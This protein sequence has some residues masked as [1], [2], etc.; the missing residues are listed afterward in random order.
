MDLYLDTGL[1]R[2]TLRKPADTSQA[3]FFAMDNS[4]SFKYHDLTETF[5]RL[6]PAL[7]A[8]CNSRFCFLKLT[9]P[10]GEHNLQVANAHA[11]LH[12]SQFNFHHLF[13]LLT[14]TRSVKISYLSQYLQ[15]PTLTS[16]ILLKHYNH[17]ITFIIETRS[18]SQPHPTWQILR[19]TRLAT[20]TIS[21]LKNRDTGRIASPG[22]VT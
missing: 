5:N 6:A 11:S 12:Q 21:W 16:D 4:Q 14:L 8:Y 18:H 2:L 7:L 1:S 10:V 13:S 3:P 22:N 19:H 9:K 20:R 15:H 17:L